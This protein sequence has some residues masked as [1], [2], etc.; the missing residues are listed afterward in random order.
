MLILKKRPDYYDYLIGVYGID[1]L[2]VF[3]RR[4][5]VATSDIYFSKY[6]KRFGYN[7]NT[8]NIF[9]GRRHYI[10][11]HLEQGV[12]EFHKFHKR[13]TDL[14]GRRVHRSA[15]LI[16]N[17]E[18]FEYF[19]DSDYNEKMRTPISMTGVYHK[20]NNEIDRI[21]ILEGFGFASIYP[22]M[23]LYSEL[24]MF[25]GWLANTEIDTKELADKEKISAKGFDTKISFRHRN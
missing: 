9:I 19:I 23:E 21:P 10:V 15:S 24:D 4:N 20:A 2:K 12:W 14:S 16:K 25:L 6:C 7:H 3:N 1:K 22:A 5:D 17:H 18:E 11:Q 8:F 13:N